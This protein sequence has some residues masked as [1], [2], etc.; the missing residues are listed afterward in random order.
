[1]R[2][3][4]YIGNWNH[5]AMSFNGGNEVR[6][7]ING[8]FD[9]VLKYL[10]QSGINSY[11]VPLEIGSVEG[12]GQRG[13]GGTFRISNS[14]KTGFS[15]GA[16]GAITDEPGTAAGLIVTPPTVGAPDLAILGLSTYPNPDGGILVQATFQ[17]QGNIST[18]NGFYTDLYV[19][20]LPTGTGDY[21]GSISFWVNDPIAA[22]TVL[23]LTTVIEQLPSA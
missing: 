7:Y 16:F 4:P 17:N 12:N 9:S 18:Q 1:M 20:H 21:T 15:Y 22:G 2:N 11:G 3:A 8:A 10:S 14:V 19:D 13:D 6:F 5:I 23:T